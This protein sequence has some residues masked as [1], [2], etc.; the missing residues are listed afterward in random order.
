M[1]FPEATLINANTLAQQLRRHGQTDIG[2]IVELFQPRN[3]R[4]VKNTVYPLRVVPGKNGGGFVMWQ[5]G[6]ARRYR[7]PCPF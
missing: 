3:A 5:D 4:E 1:P 6:S 7:I 2:D